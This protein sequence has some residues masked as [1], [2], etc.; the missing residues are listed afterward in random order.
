MAMTWNAH[1]APGNGSLAISPHRLMGSKPRPVPPTVCRRFRDPKCHVACRWDRERLNIPEGK[2]ATPA[3][4]S[5]RGKPGQM[6]RSSAGPRGAETSNVTA[7]A[8]ALHP[9]KPSSF[10]KNELRNVL[11]LEIR[12]IPGGGNTGQVWMWFPNSKKT[13]AA[14][15]DHYQLIYRLFSQFTHYTLGL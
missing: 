3:C 14:I 10:Q 11:I 1:V 8:S 7:T 13:R 2:G 15:E 9:A 6:W 12:R 5:R 4:R